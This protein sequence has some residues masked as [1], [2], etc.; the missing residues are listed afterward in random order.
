MRMSYFT[1]SLCE[2]LRDPRLTH[3]S[4]PEGSRA[5]HCDRL[6]DRVGDGHS[7][8]GGGDC[9]CHRLLVGAEK[10]ESRIDVKETTQKENLATLFK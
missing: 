5:Q 10:A 6:D 4:S 7:G 2:R 3:P 8:G 1:L 9:D